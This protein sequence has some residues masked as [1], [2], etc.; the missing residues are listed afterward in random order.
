MDCAPVCY[1]GALFQYLTKYVA[2]CEQSTDALREVMATLSRESDARPSAIFTK[3]LNK[4]H[5]RDYSAQ[6]VTHHLLKIAEARTN[7]IF[8]FASS[9]QEIDLVEKMTRRS[10]Y[11]N[12]LDRAALA[13]TEQKFVARNM[14]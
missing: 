14:S 10:A 1:L 2:K 11:Q 9:E 13:S 4:M 6:E 3:A 12:Y 5:T 7:R 8:Q